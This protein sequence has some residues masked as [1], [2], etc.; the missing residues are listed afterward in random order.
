[1]PRSPRPSSR[2]TRHS[3]ASRSGAPC[4]TAAPST[5]RP[6][7]PTPRS[8]RPRTRS[9]WG[10]RLRQ[11]HDRQDPDPARDPRQRPPG[12]RHRLLRRG[13]CLRRVGAAGPLARG[14]CHRGWLLHPQPVQR[15]VPPGGSRAAAALPD[16]GCRAGRPD[17]SGRPCSSARPRPPQGDLAERSGGRTGGAGGRPVA[18]RQADRVGRGPGNRPVSLHGRLADRPVRRPGRQ[19]SR[20]RP[21]DPVLRLQPP[22]PQLPGDPLAD[23]RDLLLG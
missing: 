2:P 6:S 3:P 20:D 1:M 11:V 14:P 8:C 23:G 12:C 19:P 16:R 22:G 15:A 17:P 5:S 9:R 4:W 7:L 18:S 21:A 13:Q 10:T